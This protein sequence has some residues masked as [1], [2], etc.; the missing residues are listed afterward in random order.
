MLEYSGV[1]WAME[2]FREHPAY[3]KPR[4]TSSS[5]NA[6][7]NIMRYLIIPPLSILTPYLQSKSTVEMSQNCSRTPGYYV[8]PKA[9]AAALPFQAR[10][11]VNT[12]KQLPELTDDQAAGY[13]DWV[14]VTINGSR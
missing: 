8:Y 13:L 6:L 11:K 7:S 5:T 3:E 12:V 10:D 4:R 1:P 9:Y 14:P 2:Q